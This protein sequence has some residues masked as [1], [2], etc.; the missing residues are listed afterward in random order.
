M[1]LIALAASTLPLVS[2]YS[3]CDPADV[4]GPITIPIQNVLVTSTI[5]AKGTIQIID[6]CT[7]ILFN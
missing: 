3:L 7:V 4:K 1:L 6:G 5:V 2:A